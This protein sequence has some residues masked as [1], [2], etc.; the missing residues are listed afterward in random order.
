MGL[1]GAGGVAQRHARVLSGFGDVE[2]V[3]VTDVLPDAA[4]RLAAQ[5][6]APDVSATSPSCSAAD[7]DA[8]YVCVPPFAHGPAEESVLGAGVPMFVEKPIA[9]DLATAERIADLV[10]R[11]GLLT[12]VGHHWRYLRVRG[13][14][15]RRCSPTGRSGWSAAPGWTRFPRSRG[16]RA[17]T[18]PAGRS[19]SRPPTCWTWSARWSARWSRSP[20]TATARPPPVDGADIDSVTTAD[21][22][23]RRRRGRHPRRRLHAGLEAP[24]RAWRSSPT[25]WRSSWPRTA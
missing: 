12:A 3:G 2:L 20:R 24:G 4:Q 6:A 9:V 7:P 25:G 5:P 8:V 10:A 13:A 17:G 11:R 19:S 15:P 21:A 18:A 14:G 16:G 23:L 1:V 22:A